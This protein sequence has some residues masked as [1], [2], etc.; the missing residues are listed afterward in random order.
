MDVRLERTAQDLVRHLPLPDWIDHQPYQSEI[1][2]TE[3]SC[4]AGGLCRLLYDSQLDLRNSEQVWHYRTVQRVLTREGAERAAHVV[5][6]FDPGYQRL[7]VHF[8]RVLRGAEA[9]D[10]AKAD[11]FQL[12]RRETNLE[13]LIFDGRLTAS[14][15][16]PD[17]RIGDIIDL[18]VTVYGNAPVL[19]RRPRRVGCLRLLQ[20][21][22]RAPA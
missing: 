11:A 17:V 21:V 9:I 10:H 19:G 1:P 20:S 7:D 13:R 18:A 14:L 6:E 8:V 12:L 15:L 2:D 5:V 22:V 16:I 3:V 4:V